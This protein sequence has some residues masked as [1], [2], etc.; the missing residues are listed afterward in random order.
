M[1]ETSGADRFKF[2]SEL[3]PARLGILDILMIGR[4]KIVDGV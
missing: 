4:E 1:I 3:S 2:V